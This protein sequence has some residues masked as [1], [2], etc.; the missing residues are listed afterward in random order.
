MIVI[1][2]LIDCSQQYLNRE[3]GVIKKMITQEAKK[4]HTCTR[5]LET[6]AG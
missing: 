1:S 6:A 2:N 4:L 5:I 3:K